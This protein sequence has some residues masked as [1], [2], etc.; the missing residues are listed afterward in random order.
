M[1]QGYKERAAVVPRAWA[2]RERPGL[3]VV[4]PLLTVRSCLPRCLR[5]TREPMGGKRQIHGPRLAR[6]PTGARKSPLRRRTLESTWWTHQ[7][8]SSSPT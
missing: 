8:R 4:V 5:W 6:M 3:V 1:I 2:W 7:H